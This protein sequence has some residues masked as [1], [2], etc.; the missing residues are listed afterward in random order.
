MKI[1]ILF[2]ILPFILFSCQKENLS[3]ITI[4]EMDNILEISIQSEKEKTDQINRVFFN[5]LKEYQR[6]RYRF[7]GSSVENLSEKYQNFIGELNE[8]IPDIK[9]SKLDIKQKVETLNFYQKKLTKID[10][11][12]MYLYKTEISKNMKSIGIREWGFTNRIKDL[13]SSLNKLSNATFPIPTNDIQHDSIFM[14]KLKMIHFGVIQR[15]NLF[16]ESFRELMG[17]NFLCGPSRRFPVVHQKKS[18][19]KKGEY[20]EAE[21][22]VVNYFDQFDIHSSDIIVNNDTLKFDTET[23]FANLKIKANQRGEFELNIK[24][25]I[26]NDLTGEKSGGQI[27]HNYHVD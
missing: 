22:G 4:Q 16:S 6:S 24:C 14:L 17:G 13:S 25:N 15:I 10:S 20:F 5:D 9:E 7:L 1:R 21:I 12:I 26:M 11:S 27:I 2:T 3:K 19:I 8:G 18:H 23:G